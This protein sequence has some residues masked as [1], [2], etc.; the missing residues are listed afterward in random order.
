LLK[1]YINHVG[2]FSAHSN[3]IPWFLTHILVLAITDN[4]DDLNIHF[5]DY[6]VAAYGFTTTKNRRANV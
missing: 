3:Y 4:A 2:W 5:P 6:D 1:W